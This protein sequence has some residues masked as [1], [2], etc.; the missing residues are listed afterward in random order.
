MYP[1][2]F[3]WGV[4]LTIGVLL[5]AVAFLVGYLANVSPTV[6]TPPRPTVT[7]TQPPSG[8][9]AP[10]PTPTPTPTRLPK[11]TVQ[12][13][14]ARQVVAD[15]TTHY[16]HATYRN[17]N[18]GR[19]A[20]LI[21]GTAMSPGDVFSFN[22]VV[23][24]RTRARGFV[25]GFVIQNGIY[26]SDLGGGV[27]QVATTVYNAALL[28]GL[29]IIERHPHSFFI[30]RYPIGRDA[31]VAWGTSDL[32]FKNNTPYTILIQANVVPSTPSSAGSMHVRFLSTKYWDVGFNESEPTRFRQP[33]TRYVTTAPCVPNPVGTKGFDI[34][35]YRDVYK[36]S[37]SS[38]AVTRS[39]FVLDHT[40][41]IHTRYAPLD[42]VVC[43]PSPT[44]SPSG[45]P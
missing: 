44:P 37:E 42:Q 6:L 13:P 22:A 33:Q 5:A 10:T 27:S 34:N 8:S 3:K 25:K 36:P 12:P 43:G 29:Q 32:Q 1:A 14:D 7:V 17:I 35:V 19:A 31:T 24:E 2:W 41:V 9:S 28:A 11:P 45:T 39:G 40:D 26:A 16:P 38:P 30:D 4:G 18:Q 21:N 23:G 15:Y 20:Q